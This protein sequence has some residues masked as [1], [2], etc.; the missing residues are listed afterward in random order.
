MRVTSWFP[1]NVIGTNVSTN[2][3]WRRS[4]WSSSWK[5]PSL[6][7]LQMAFHSSYCVTESNV[8]AV[9]MPA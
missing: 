8:V 1:M 2:S 5:L 3:S 9:T 6:R 4:A 7:L